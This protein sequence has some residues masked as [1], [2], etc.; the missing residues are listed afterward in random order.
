MPARTSRVF[1]A[2]LAIVAGLASASAQ[3]GTTFE[4]ISIKPTAPGTYPREPWPSLSTV[5]PTGRYRA[6]NMTIGPL[7]RQ[8]F[9]DPGN[10]NLPQLIDEPG[11]TTTDKY[12]IEARFAAL[13]SQVELN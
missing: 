9:R 10:P 11:W 6:M 5:Q 3:R 13:T 12:E 4:V 2:S 1:I 8:A 7:I